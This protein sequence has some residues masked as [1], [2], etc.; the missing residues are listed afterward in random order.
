VFILA[1]IRIFA[2]APYPGLERIM[3]Q[4]AAQRPELELISTVASL[5]TWRQ[6]L[7]SVPS[8]SYD[9]IISRGGTARA[10]RQV[11][12][13]PVVEIGVS[14]YDMLCSLKNA[15]NYTGK[16]AVMGHP[17]ITNCAMQLSDLMQYDVTVCTIHNDSDIKQ[18]LLRLKN[19]G[20]NLIL[21]DNISQHNAE[22]LGLNSMLITSGEKSV[23]DALDEAV[24]IIKAQ[25]HLLYQNE[26]Y[27]QLF[28][29][30]WDELTVFS[31]QGQLQ[32]STLPQDEAHTPFLEMLRTRLPKPEHLSF[33]DEWEWGGEYWQ[34]SG[35]PLP[36][37]QGMAAAL[38]LKKH[39]RSLLIQGEG[40]SMLGRGDFQSTDLLLAPGPICVG[41][42]GESI[43]ACAASPFP[44]LILGEEGTGKDRVA[45]QL[46]K[47]GAGQPALVTLDCQ[48]ICEKRWKQ[49]LSSEDSPL[50]RSGL[51]FYLKNVNFLS[52][53]QAQALF[54][55]MEI[56]RLDRRTRLIF[57]CLLDGS[58]SENDYA[59]RY[60]KNHFS[61]LLLRL[62]PLRQRKED[63]PNLL[64]LYI[65]QLNVSLGKQVVGFTPGALERMVEFDWQGNLTQLNRVTRTLVVEARTPYIGE[66]QV[67]KLLRQEAPLCSAAPRPGSA[68]LDLRKPLSEIQYDVIRLVLQ[69]ENGNQSRS[70]ARLGISRSTLWNTLKKHV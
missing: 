36:T 49:L 13:V 51:A 42:L 32:Y 19:E 16:F 25:N 39:S 14:I 33:E 6:A 21:C 29:L 31:P 70:A 30:Q 15:Q 67:E 66:E 46:C 5:P 52:S 55:Y 34:V 44:V 1:K 4:L 40:V 62:P 17:N 35:Q 60:L 18:E 59:C 3:Q 43:A 20:C 57:S 22:E 45:V 56:T 28:S 38:C 69:E 41:E 26:L 64:A 23:S 53:E 8:S 48:V 37:D 58:H 63:I 27:R 68:V 50:L 61:T 47:S 24:R 2:I 54:E 9:V 12:G 7:Q 10:L 65:N 11:A